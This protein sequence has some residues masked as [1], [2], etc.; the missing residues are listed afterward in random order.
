MSVTLNSVLGADRPV[1][2][3]FIDTNEALWAA[4]IPDALAFISAYHNPGE[5]GTFFCLQSHEEHRG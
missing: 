5:S 2:N 1:D 3:L 4:G